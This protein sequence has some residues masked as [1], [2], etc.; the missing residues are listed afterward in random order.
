MHND[1][2]GCMY[3]HI[4]MFSIIIWWI[5]YTNDSSDN[6]DDYNDLLNEPGQGRNKH[7]KNGGGGNI[8]TF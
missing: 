3:I 7:F 1:M 6:R 4:Q 5:R 8:S 2:F